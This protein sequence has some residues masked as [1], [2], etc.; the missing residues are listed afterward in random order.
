LSWPV[1]LGCVW[2]VGWG[3]M[4]PLHSNFYSVWFVNT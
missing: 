4:E 2:L 1:A 3:W